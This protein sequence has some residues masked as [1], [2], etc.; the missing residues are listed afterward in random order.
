MNKTRR[1]LALCLL[2]LTVF[3]MTLPAWAEGDDDQTANQ[4]SLARDITSECT[5]KGQKS[6]AGS[7]KRAT[8]NNL[9]TKFVAAN[10]E[11][12]IDVF[13]PDGVKCAGL[14]MDFVEIP[15]K[16]SVYYVT[17]SGEEFLRAEGG[18]DSYM[19]QQ[20]ADVSFMPIS[21]HVRLRSD[22]LSMMEFRVYDDSGEF[23]PSVTKIWNERP[24]KADLMVVST[25]PDDE[26]IFIGGVLP[27]Y[28]GDQKKDTVVVYMT[29][30][31]RRRASELLNGLW[32]C[33]VRQYPVLGP[34][35]DKYCTS[36]GEARKYWKDEDCQ[37][38]LVE[39]IRR[40]KPEVL[41][42]QDVNGEYGHGAHRLTV[43]SVQ[44]AI[45]LAMDPT[46]FPD[47]YEKYGVW[48]VKKV[49]L[50]LWK[51]NKISMNWRIP[52]DSFDGKTALDIAKL[53]YG[54]HISQH[55]WYFQV[56]DTGKTS[57]A[58]FGLYYTTVGLDQN[59]DD[60]FE[61]IP[62]PTPEPTPTPVPTP[63]PTP[64]PTPTPQPT[65]AP[66]ITPVVTQAPS[67]PD[68]TPMPLAPVESPTFW[69]RIA[70][71]FRNLF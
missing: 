1:I 25:H 35:P 26:L 8:D 5:F 47:L 55:K 40:Y 53:A 51:E 60:M 4:P 20:F 23:A 57:N 14:Y 41:V 6:S 46:A 66:D 50:H 10:N 2:V 21:E 54:E 17:D 49:Y 31:T 45:Q 7:F 59:G 33:G 18:R 24:E 37:R 62:L 12:Y 3:T 13:L 63:E 11:E 44:Q 67:A 30:A 52:L 64:V 48:E 56:L 71:F 36:I 27:T 22:K 38:Y 39:Q 19:L 28:A 42:T 70:E 68:F 65:A 34:F 29:Y 43:Y 61:N 16:W 9:E 32:V 15:F 69:Q 58:E